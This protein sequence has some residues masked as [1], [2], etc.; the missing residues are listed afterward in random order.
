VEVTNVAIYLCDGA[1]PRLAAKRGELSVDGN[2]LAHKATYVEGDLLVTPIAKVASRP[3]GLLIVRSSLPVDDG[4]RGFVELAGA[5]IAASLLAAY[6]RAEQATAER[7]N[8]AK[9]EFMAMLGHELRNPLAP[10][11]TALE[12]MRLRGTSGLERERAVIERQTDHLAGLVEDLLDVSRITRGTVQLRRERLRL[13]RIIARAAETAAPLFEQ[14]RH[15]LTT[16][17]ADHIMI[18][19]DEGRMTQVFSNLLTNAAKYTDPGGRVSIR[20]T[21]ADG[22]VV[23]AVQDS[24][25]G[26]SAEMLPRVF[27]LFTQERQNIDRSQGG[28]G[29]GLAIVK[30][31]VE[32]HGGQVGALSAGPDQ[33][34]TFWVR[35]P[36][37][38]EQARD[39][40]VAADASYRTAGGGTSVLIVDDNEDAALMLADLLSGIGYATRVAHDAPQA[41]AMA[42]EY[43]PDVA[44]LDIGLPAMD[45]YE[46]ARRLREK[47][48]W[49]EVRLI[50][51]TGYGQSSDRKRS[52]EAGFD[53]HLVKPIGLA[54]LQ[55]VIPRDEW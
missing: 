30:S 27:D 10:I 2:A 23:V 48:A 44:L 3:H 33:G 42:D 40:G 13:S 24:G 49:G 12:L 45:G 47:P 54:A 18:D 22:D 15:Q 21:L 14:R 20:A 29:L 37:I 32:L 5:L 34:S 52:L 7:A 41:L 50:A 39:E 1:T 36:H 6:S 26:M 19:G 25:R 31:L 8:R 46:L 38:L 17:V 35:M 4:L 28:L 53:H 43:V 9:D 55:E 11:R 51:V 16:D